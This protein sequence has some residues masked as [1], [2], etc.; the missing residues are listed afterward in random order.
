VCMTM[1]VCACV[2][3]RAQVFITIILIELFGSPFM[4]NSSL[5]LALMVGLIVSAI[6]KVILLLQAAVG[7]QQHSGVLLVGTRTGRLALLTLFVTLCIV[8]LSDRE[9]GVCTA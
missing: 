6:V 3:I 8:Y 4:R 9:P 1:S 5:V 7:S 2:C